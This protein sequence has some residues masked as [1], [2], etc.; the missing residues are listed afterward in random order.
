MST[1]ATR[2]I[3]TPATIVIDDS[4]T[5]ARLLDARATERPAA[6]FGEYR[7][8]DDRWAAITLEQFRHDVR[9]L[10]KGL[11]ASSVRPGDTVGLMAST[12]YEWAVCDS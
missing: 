10:A 8:S 1:A 11:I 2:E 5:L 12:R 3:H 4:L 6:P 9:T 7:G